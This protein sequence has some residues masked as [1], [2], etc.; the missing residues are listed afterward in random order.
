MRKRQLK[1]LVLGLALL[2]ILTLVI[3]LPRT[4]PE[5]SETVASVGRDEITRQEWLQELEERYGE[6]ILE[7]MVNQKVIEKLAEEYD[8]TLAE[9]DV[10]QELAIYK[11][12][13]GYT[14]EERS[15]H[16]WKERVKLSLYFE[17]LLA[18]D[19][20]FTEAELREYYN[21]N[22]SQFEFAPAYHLSQIVVSSLKEAEQT[23]KELEE[24]SSFDALAMERSID[25]FTA[26][27]GGNLGFVSEG[28]ET[29]EPEILAEAARM[30]ESS[31]SDPIKVENG[32]T[33]VYL[34]EKI[35]AKNYS[36]KEVKNRVRRQM[37]AEQMEGPL[38]ARVF[39]DEAGATWFY[40]EN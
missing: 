36:F 26:S 35:E 37:A 23:A 18:K 3:L 32:Y 25:E 34:H 14:G 9:S 17:E 12:L 22:R 33:I 4:Q 10:E 20:E 28:N 11:M 38:D 2:N 19:A 27:R 40:G 5:E 8:I 30:E 39:W 31:W 13:Y 7:D 24:G 29:I 6:P 21:E 15:E 1:L 16:E